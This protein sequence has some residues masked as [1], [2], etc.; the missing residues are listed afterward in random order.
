MFE[1]TANDQNFV[2]DKSNSSAKFTS[3]KPNFPNP[4]AHK[5]TKVSYTK[6]SSEVQT[7]NHWLERN[8]KQYQSGKFSQHQ[9]KNAYELYLNESSSGSSFSKESNTPVQKWQPISKVKHPE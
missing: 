1:K 5:A 4:S 8:G 3:Q 9:I 7:I 2:N 6:S